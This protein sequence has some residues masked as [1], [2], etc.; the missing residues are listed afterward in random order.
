VRLQSSPHAGI[1]PASESPFFWTGTGDLITLLPEER[2]PEFTGHDAREYTYDE[3]S[4]STGLSWPSTAN[5]ELRTL[6]IGEFRGRVLFRMECMSASQ[7]KPDTGYKIK[8]YNFLPINEKIHIFQQGKMA[9][10]YA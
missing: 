8:K 2:D 6:G 1:E 7:Q 10:F 9:M 5:R 4:T 3:I